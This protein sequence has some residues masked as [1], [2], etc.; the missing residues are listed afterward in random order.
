[1]TFLITSLSH[2][3]AAKPK[4]SGVKKIF[5]SLKID[6]KSHTNLTLIQAAHLYHCDKL[7][8]ILGGAIVSHS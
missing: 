1:M 4:I 6:P 2:L 8:E 7:D 5:R 3:N